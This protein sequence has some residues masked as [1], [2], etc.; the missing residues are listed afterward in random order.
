MERKGLRPSIGAEKSGWEIGGRKKEIAG[1]FPAGEGIGTRAVRQSR[2][3]PQS[4]G[5]EKYLTTHG[6][7]GGPRESQYRCNER[8]K[9]RHAL[10][11][12]SRFCISNSRRG[13]A[14]VIAREGGGSIPRDSFQ[15]DPAALSFQLELLNT[16]PRR[17]WNEFSS[18]SKNRASSSI[19]QAR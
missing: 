7:G 8:G 1:V 5:F 14:I 15:S 19:F 18:P 13:Y 6:E 4:G 16:V 9:S 17:S 2:A 12:T 3:I 11:S 10:Q